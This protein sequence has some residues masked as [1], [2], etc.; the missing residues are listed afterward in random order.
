MSTPDKQ[1]ILEELAD[2]P[3][4]RFLQLDG[5]ANVEPDGVMHGDDEGDLT[6]LGI[7]HELMRSPG[8]DLPVRVLI[9]EDADLE[10]VRRLLTKMLDG[11]D[12]YFDH[13]V[14]DTERELLRR[15]GVQSEIA[16]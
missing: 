15:A 13:L 16:F 5:W 1:E 10:D 3:V 8:R 11:L 4:Q 2:K 14:E 12:G 7:T 9:H 6:M